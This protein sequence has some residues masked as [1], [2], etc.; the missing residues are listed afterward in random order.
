MSG[1]RAA[2]H[3]DE[4][5][6]AQAVVALFLLGLVA[7]SGLVADGG[8][9][10]AERRRLQNLADSAAAAGA[11]QLDVAAYRASGGA[12]SLDQAAARRSAA[13]RL[14]SA[15][16]VSADVRAGGRLVSVRVERSIG[17]P[18]LGVLGLGPVAVSARSEAEPQAGVGGRP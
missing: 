9:V 3:P 18:F 5:G 2:L 10:L 8:M 17:L 14:V 1:R 15:P 12:V 16:G 11:M 7:V 4:R 6:S 13:S